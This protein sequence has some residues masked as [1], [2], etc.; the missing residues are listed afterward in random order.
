MGGLPTTGLLLLLAAASDQSL[1]HAVELHEALLAPCRG[2]E[3]QGERAFHDPLTSGFLRPRS[4]DG[5]EFAWARSP[6]ATWLVVAD[7]PGPRRLV[8]TG[9]GME[10]GQP[11]SISVNGVDLGERRLIRAWTES[12]WPL[13][14]EVARPGPN[15]F[16]LWSPT[17]PRG[18][19]RRVVAVDSLHIEPEA[20]SCAGAPVAPVA[21]PSLPLT[22][23][24]GAI[25][26]VPVLVPPEGRLALR[27]SG[28]P[29]AAADV[30]VAL[31]RERKPA[32]AAPVP[33]SGSGA[34][35]LALPVCCGEDG[36]L[37]LAGR[38]P[39]EVRLEA[40][41]V[42]GDVSPEAWGRV[43]GHPLLKQLLGVA[44]LAGLFLVSAWRGWRLPLERQAPWIDLLVVAAVALL[45]RHLYL[46]AYPHGDP[47]VFPDAHEYLQRARGL[48]E[49]RR[50]L[51]GD[52]SWHRWQTWLR[53]PGYY[54]F[55]A[56]L[57]RLG[58]DSVAAIVRIQTLLWA[59]SALSTY[60]LGRV[61]FGR[62]AG[63][64]AGLAFALSLEG[65]T[66]ASV[67][68]SE[69]LFLFLLV[70][71]LAL[72]AW[73]AKR[74]AVWP[75]LVA[76]LL[77]G[78]AALVRSAPMVFVPAAA[79]L[80]GLH[81]GLRRALRP[82]AAL[83][84]GMALFVVPWCVRNS[85]L[86][87]R[88]MGLDNMAV[89]NFLASHPDEAYLGPGDFDLES[90]RGWDLY[91]RRIKRAGRDLAG[92]PVLGRG[93]RRLASRPGDTLRSVGTGLR[94]FFHPFT[95]R[96]S[97]YIDERDPC[98]IMAFT[99]LLNWQLWPVL[100]LGI[101]AMVVRFRERAN[102]P[103]V[104][105]FLL[106]LGTGTVLFPLADLPRYRFSTMP[107]LLAFAGWAVAGGHRLLGGALRGRG[108]LPPLRV[109]PP[110]PGVSGVSGDTSTES[111]S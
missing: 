69:A 77:F 70:P 110:P 29:G 9:R 102:W 51:F 72:L 87:G 42:A 95:D 11:V 109:G 75:A 7:G 91:Y 23:A 46:A 108:S 19:A 33:A 10:E 52:L 14:P 5:R 41:E 61:M 88:P 98:R 60:S 86:S 80:L 18:E 111:S 59:A 4:R 43:C 21:E 57:Q 76:G 65:L 81:H 49:G 55:V 1:E 96:F 6:A 82:M 73:L 62:A 93:L 64:F 56:Q 12:S 25:V 31:G 38:G 30:L 34:H 16:V 84:L 66:F 36:V 89:P 101:G 58:V 71:A 48:A 107:V 106:I 2:W 74:P 54:F 103:V 15:L 28:A 45:A 63:L 22:L 40:L 39:G 26:T 83:V 94:R 44:M 90:D 47:G 13:P 68:A 27:V 97:K 67:I 92:E 24:P 32:G 105:W 17:E 20:A 50:S 3:L 8:L 99:G 37:A 35:E 53:P 79:A 100:V 85:V 78:L 104:V